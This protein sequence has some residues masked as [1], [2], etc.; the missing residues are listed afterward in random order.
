MNFL[1]NIQ[2]CFK[3]DRVYYTRHSKTEMKTEE[4]GQIF[5]TE[6]Y[7][8]IL[9]GEIIEEY[10]NDKPYPS[11]LVLGHTLLKRPLHIVCAYDKIE[12][13]VIIVT[14]YQPNPNLWTVYKRRK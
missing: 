10:M 1:K 9:N 5:E 13:T 14:V 7:E 8:A 6:V 2:E 11:I 12:N 4:F 3:S